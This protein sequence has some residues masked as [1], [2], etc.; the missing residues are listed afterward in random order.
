M[1]R[2]DVLDI[3]HKRIKELKDDNKELKPRAKSIRDYEAQMLEANRVVM[4]ELETL[5]EEINKL[6]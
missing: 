6:D 1:T 2:K 5:I 4:T 3:I